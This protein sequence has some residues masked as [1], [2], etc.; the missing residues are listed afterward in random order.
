MKNITYIFI[1][2]VFFLIGCGPS[3]QEQ[4]DEIE[5]ALKSWFGKSETELVAKWGAP[6][7]SYK[8]MYGAR[9]LTYIYRHTASSPAY[10]WYDYWGNAHF[11]RP[12]RHQRT[13][14]RSFTVDQTGT[15]IAYHWEG[16]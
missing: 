14:E 9:E 13:T 15:V 12:V 16:F 7:K 8:T 1:T 3:L 6:T 10:A 11:S 5:K 4:H 2:I